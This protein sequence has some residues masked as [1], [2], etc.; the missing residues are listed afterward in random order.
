MPAYFNPAYFK[1]GQH[2]RY[3]GFAA[4]IVRYYCEGMWEVRLPGGAACVS[5][6][7]LTAR[8]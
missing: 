5:G 4:T 3:G 2:V 7:D 6:A 1:P 8:P